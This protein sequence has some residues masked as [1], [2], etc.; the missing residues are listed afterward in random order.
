MVIT[1]VL[2]ERFNHGLELL[3]EI[4]IFEDLGD[5]KYNRVKKE[6]PLFAID[7][8]SYLGIINHFSISMIFINEIEEFVFSKS[9]ALDK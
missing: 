2:I 3:I 5:M 8:F 9:S 6:L 7:Y 1:V 4:Q